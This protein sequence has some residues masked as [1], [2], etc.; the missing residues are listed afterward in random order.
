M[1]S[2]AKPAS[3]AGQYDRM[4][5]TPSQLDAA[6]REQLR[7]P[8]K[9]AIHAVLF[10]VGDT[11]L[12][13]APGRF[14]ELLRGV[15]RALYDQ[16]REAGYAVPGYP[17][18]HRGMGYRLVL[19]AAWSQLIGRE[20]DLPRVTR[21]VMARF[22]IH[23]P[24]A[25]VEEWVLQSMTS[26]I[27]HLIVEPTA[28]RTIEHLAE[29]GIKM[30]VIS[31][32][33]IPKRAVDEGL[34]M[35]GLIEHLPV[36]IY[37]SDVRFMKPH[38]AIFRMALDQLDAQPHRTLFVGNRMSK[39]VRGAARMGMKTAL[40]A[41][42]GRRPPNRRPPHVVLRQLADLLELVQPVP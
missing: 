16:A 10:D 20:I 27:E 25:L 2:E 30:G 4:T 3:D 36:R 39:D 17:R 23:A 13:F 5:L 40:L 19:A 28:K 41:P 14:R 15:S 6:R 24:G 38:R 9:L 34:R 33:L 21:S 26:L 35:S 29:A 31:N 32:T 12:H 1:L 7:P 37:S 22:A 18:F 11:L 8:E 42:N